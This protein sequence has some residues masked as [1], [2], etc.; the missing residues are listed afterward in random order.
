MNIISIHFKYLLLLPGLACST[1]ETLTTL[2]FHNSA[3]A[4]VNELLIL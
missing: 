4:T 1:W 2:K 3:A